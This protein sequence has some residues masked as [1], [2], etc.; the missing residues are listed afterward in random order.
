[1]LNEQ[2]LTEA[3]AF[4][5]YK[6]MQFE[7]IAGRLDAHC[8]QL[9]EALGL[10]RKQSEEQQ[11]LLQRP[12]QTEELRAEIDLLKESNAELAK[13]KAGEGRICERYWHA[14]KTIELCH[15][16]NTPAGVA[17]AKEALMIPPEL[18]LP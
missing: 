16:Q 11:Q 8:K 5:S 6:A 7:L 18:R 4:Q 17:V 9:D 10:L 2:Q 15:D 13:R 12:D 14:L 3:L 1:M